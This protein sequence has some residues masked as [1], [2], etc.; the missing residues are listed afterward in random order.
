MMGCP[1]L[2]QGSWPASRRRAAHVARALWWA[3]PYPRWAVVPRAASWVLVHGPQRG[4]P[5]GMMVGQLVPGHMRPAM[6]HLRWC[7]GGPL[8]APASRAGWRMGYLPVGLWAP[9]T[10]A[11]LWCP[12]RSCSGVVS[13]LRTPVP[14]RR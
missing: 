8:L 2:A 14:H 11:V 10:G 9:P 3:V 5:W 13:V 12:A 1:H 6:V 4:V 7:A